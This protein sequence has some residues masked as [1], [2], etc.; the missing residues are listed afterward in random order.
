MGRLCAAGV[1]Q[2]VQLLD[3]KKKIW[4]PPHRERSN[5]PIK[6]KKKKEAKYT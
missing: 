5:I 1:K 6:K 2:T 3:P 4:L